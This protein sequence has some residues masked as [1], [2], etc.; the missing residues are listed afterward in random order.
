MNQENSNRF[1]AAFA[2]IEKRLR[3]LTK[4]T[5]GDT[6]SSLLSRANTE[7]SV[8]RFAEDLHEFGDLR[9]AIVHERGGGFVIAEPHETTVD[10]LE[11]IERYISKPPTVENLRRIKV[12]TCGL[13]DRIGKAAKI[14][15]DSKF[16]Q[17]PVYDNGKCIGLLTTQAIAW[18]V[19]TQFKTDIG[20]LEEDSVEQVL[21]HTDED[22]IYKFV[23]RTAAI[24][25]VVT[26]FEQAAHNG[27]ILSAVMVTANG[28]SNE[29]PLG[30]LTVYDL[31]QLYRKIELA[32]AS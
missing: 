10:R 5:K 25:D 26:L 30:I 32:P 12:V 31:P 16:S 14:M 18:W 22:T 7:P 17:L 29:Q 2:R 21:R 8:K 19:A 11:Q 9:N 23:L 1:L 15:L 6:F 13:A 3:E 20:L 4:G 28:K 24:I 27:K